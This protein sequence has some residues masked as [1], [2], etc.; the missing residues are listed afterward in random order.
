MGVALAGVSLPIFFTG[1]LS[2]SIF[3]YG[4]KWHLRRRRRYIAVTEN[5]LDLGHAPA[6]AVDHPG[7]PLRR[8][9]TP[10]SPGPACWRR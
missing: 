2:L 4:L 8:A 7:L 9:R 5:P 10:G 6:A 3:S 1:L